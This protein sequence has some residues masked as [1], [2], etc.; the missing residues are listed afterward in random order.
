MT[1]NDDPLVSTDWL[2]AH[3]DDPKVQDHRCVLQDAR[4][5]AVAVG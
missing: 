1:T 5:A 3:I 4:R 2:A